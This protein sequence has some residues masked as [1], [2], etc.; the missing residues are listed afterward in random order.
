MKYF[1]RL[2]KQTVGP[3][4]LTELVKAGIRPSTYIWRKGMPDWIPASDDPEIC[5]ALRRYLAGLDPESGREIKIAAEE[6]EADVAQST[7]PQND[8]GFHG[9]RNFPEN[10]DTTDYSVKPQGVS[11]IVALLM[12]F[13]CFPVT[14]I[15]AVFFAMR[16]QAHWKMSEQE[17]LSAKDRELCRRKAHDDARLYRMML[18]ITFSIGLIIVGLAF[19]R[20]FL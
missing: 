13:I 7:E 9:I 4:S 14:G 20:V 8:T 16:T 2:N 5:R 6:Q 11:V 1:A 12:T 19:S 15:I 3:L 10:P 18:G 17:G